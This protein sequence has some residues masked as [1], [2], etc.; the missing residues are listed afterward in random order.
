MIEPPRINTEER[1]EYDI[2]DLEYLSKIAINLG[3]QSHPI[4]KNHFQKCFEKAGL[5]GFSEDYYVLFRL[6]EKIS[7]AAEGSRYIH[8][9]ISK[10]P[11]YPHPSNYIFNSGAGAGVDTMEDSANMDG[12]NKASNQ[13]NN[14]ASHGVA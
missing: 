11:N 2:S 4:I 1:H 10:C 7:A 6:L 13:N 5:R 8:T 14:S 12:I 3:V 9:G